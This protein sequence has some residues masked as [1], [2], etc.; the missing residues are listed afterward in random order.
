MQPSRRAIQRYLLEDMTVV[1][2]SR[3]I[4]ISSR[5]TKSKDREKKLPTRKPT[6]KFF[7]ERFYDH[8]TF[9]PFARFG[10]WH[11]EMVVVLPCF[12]A[13]ISGPYIII[14]VLLVS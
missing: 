1:S 2:S 5:K 11:L 13:A 4:V 14:K 10:T 8:L 9:K 6:F 12:C 7:N 3:Q